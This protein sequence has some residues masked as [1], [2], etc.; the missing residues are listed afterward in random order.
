[1]KRLDS[2]RAGLIEDEATR[3]L[4]RYGA[5]EL[6]RGRKTSPLVV[7]LRQFLSP[8]IYVM[9]VAA[10]GKNLLDNEGAGNL[11]CQ[12]SSTMRFSL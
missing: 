10:G 11:F 12:L 7:F 3:R 5:N 8:L 4:E 1:M 6:K 2:R 9:L